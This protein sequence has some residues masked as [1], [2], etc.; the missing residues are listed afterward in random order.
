[1]NKLERAVENLIKAAGKVHPAIQAMKQCI[2]AS[3]KTGRRARKYIVAEPEV[4]ETKEVVTREVEPAVAAKESK[5][6]KFTKGSQEAKDF[7]DM[8]RQR[9]KAK[10]IRNITIS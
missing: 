5:K 10:K 1:M 8:L 6:G 7:M 9:R 2:P 4:E 3:N